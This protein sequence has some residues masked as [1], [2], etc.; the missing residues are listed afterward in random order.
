MLDRPCMQLL[1]DF[2]NLNDAIFDLLLL[3]ALPAKCKNRPAKIRL[4]LLNDIV[5]A[6]HLIKVVHNFDGLRNVM[7]PL[8]C[9][10]LFHGHG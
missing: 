8:E 5:V 2:K 3:K 10:N 4:G 9:P 6:F 1:H 7:A